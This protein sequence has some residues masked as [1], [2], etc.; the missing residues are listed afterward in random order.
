MDTEGPLYWWQEW[1]T[2]LCSPRLLWLLLL[3]SKRMTGTELDRKCGGE[4]R[5]GLEC[6]SLSS[7]YSFAPF[8]LVGSV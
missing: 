1:G 2:H 4:D 8:T 3:V 7:S 6:H 5:D